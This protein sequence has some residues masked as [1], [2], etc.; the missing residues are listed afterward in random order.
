[1]P[2]REFSLFRWRGTP[3]NLVIWELAMLEVDAGYGT[4][5]S[6]YTAVLPGGRHEQWELLIEG[7]LQYLL[8]PE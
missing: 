1:M 8:S 7:F 2:I 6:A 3:S 5:I 4:A